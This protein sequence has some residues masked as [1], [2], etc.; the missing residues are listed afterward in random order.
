MRIAK[1]LMVV[2][3]LLFFGLAL[4]LVPVQA[5]EEH[6]FIGTKA[7][8]KCHIKEWRSWNET[9]MS[10]AYDILLP[11]ERAEAKTEHGLDPDKD[12]TQD[13]SCLSC[14]TTGFG[15]PG[16]FVSLEETPQLVGASC[17]VCHGAG[18]TYTRDDL[19][20][21]ENKEYP[22]ADV[23][24]AGMTQPPIGVEVCQECHNSDNPTAPDEEFDFEQRMKD[25]SHEN[26][27]F[28]YEH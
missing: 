14:H 28:K 8:K 12:Y 3:C 10:K 4:A 22:L 16:G 5:Q 1:T 17:E 27:P 26:Y 15:K 18:G 11:G 7:C 24:A 13:E 19:M 23:V 9:K 6:E 2:L 25:G 21:N 20:S